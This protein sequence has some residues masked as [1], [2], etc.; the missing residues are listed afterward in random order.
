MI[1][2]YTT[3][4]LPPTSPIP[5]SGATVTPIE[6]SSY[7]RQLDG[8]FKRYTPERLVYV[9]I[10][11]DGGSTCTTAPVVERFVERCCVLVAAVALRERSAIVGALPYRRRSPLI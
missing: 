6:L 9:R 2:P 5:P 1:A 4:V 3:S 11:L 7:T 8:M 10:A